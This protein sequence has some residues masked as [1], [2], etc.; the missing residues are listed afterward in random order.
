MS[1]LRTLRNFIN[2]ESVTSAD[3]RTSEVISPVSGKAYATAPVSG[4]EDVDRAMKAAEAAFESW[5]ETTPSQRQAALLKLADAMEARADEIV[6]VQRENTAK[7]HRLPQQ[8]R[9]SP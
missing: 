1:D 4:A 2:G 5:R 6:Q 7:P 8:E 3:G 9:I